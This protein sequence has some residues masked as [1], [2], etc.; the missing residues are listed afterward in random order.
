MNENLNLVEILKDCP[1]GT[2]LYS[3]MF[4]E[5]EYENI[6]EDV[7]YPITFKTNKGTPSSVTSDGKYFRY[8]DGECTLFPNKEQRD[9][10]KFTAPWYNIEKQDK[11]KKQVH[12]PK[13]TFDDVLALQCCMETVKKVQEDKELYEK[14]NLIH[15]KMYDAYWFE[16][17]GEQ[18]LSQTNER[19]W[20]YLVSDVLTWKN[21]IG[22][23]LDDP[24]VQELAKRLCS[25]YAQKL[26]NPSILFNSSSTGK[27]KQKFDPKTLKAFD[28][29]LTRNNKLVGWA[30]QLFSHIIE[31]ELHYPYYCINNSYKYCIP[32]NDDTKHLVGTNEEAPEYYRYWED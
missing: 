1:K 6:N 29:V 12:F 19:A 21:G 20:L 31:G 23:Y 18:I 8:Y 4:G 9:W 17:Q 24:R 32:Y 5:V 13:F 7:E 10:S 11:H 14:L 3:T 28:R 25:N 2:K 22:Q 16:K 27:N 30:V 15:S 26:Y